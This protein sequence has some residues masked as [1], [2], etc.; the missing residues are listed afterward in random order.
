M[1]HDQ[2]QGKMGTQRATSNILE[3]YRPSIREA[4][5]EN[6]AAYDSSPYDLIRYY[7]G[8]TNLSGDVAIGSEG[9]GLR[10]SLC[11]FSSL[12]KEYGLCNLVYA[13]FHSCR[14]LECL[15]RIC[16]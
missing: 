5:Y 12:C 11:L 10:P 15:D 13:P 2:R 16:K 7:M 4:L 1:K 3:R 14:M 6:L 8:W 9:K